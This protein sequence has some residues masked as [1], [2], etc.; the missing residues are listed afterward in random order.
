MLAQPGQSIIDMASMSGNGS[1]YAFYLAIFNSLSPTD[2]IIPGQN[3]IEP[4]FIKSDFLSFEQ[5]LKQ[6][7]ISFCQMSLVI[8]INLY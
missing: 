8:L 7:E 4:N 1:G 2:I 5:L 3:L 6:N